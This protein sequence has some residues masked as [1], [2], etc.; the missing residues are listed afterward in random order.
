MR[1]DSLCARSRTGRGWWVFSGFFGSLALVDCVGVVTGDA[2][3][4]K[5]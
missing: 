4:H 5:N 2:E 3:G 1:L